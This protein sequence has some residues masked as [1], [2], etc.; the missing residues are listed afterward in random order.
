MQKIYSNR[1][2]KEDIEITVLT[3]GAFNVSIVNSKSNLVS[4]CCINLIFISF[5][6]S[7]DPILVVYQ[8]HS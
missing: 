6:V 8:Y 4:F 3:L 2:L 1:S 5:S 7:N